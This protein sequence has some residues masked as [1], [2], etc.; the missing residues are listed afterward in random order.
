MKCS[1]IAH[2]EIVWVL[3][4][5]TLFV[6][7][8]VVGR[9]A[10]VVQVECTLFVVVVVEHKAPVVVV[11]CTLFGVVGRKAP[12][13]VMVKC[14]LFSSMVVFVMAPKRRSASSDVVFNFRN[15]RI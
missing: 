15:I 9:K 10:A 13:V 14:T 11:E 1:Q 12:V 7:V 3:M 5:C 4:E 2:L 6:V 8:V